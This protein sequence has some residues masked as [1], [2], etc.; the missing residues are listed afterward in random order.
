MSGFE[1]IFKS[2]TCEH[3]GNEIQKGDKKRK[4]GVAKDIG[5]EMDPHRHKPAG[6]G[7]VIAPRAGVH[8][9]GS[10]QR[11]AVQPKNPTV[12]N[13]SEQPDLSK[14]LFPLNSNPQLVQY[15]GPENDQSL[16]KSIEIA[17]QPGS[18]TESGLYA[19][20]RRNLA[21]EQESA[22]MGLSKADKDDASD[23]TGDDDDESASD[24]EGST[25][26]T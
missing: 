12:T 8:K 25:T 21:M 10:V 15:V 22:K 14:A 4:K 1:D 9:T 5:N 17:A 26:E 16:A 3:C 7:P 11:N 6:S 23:E 18:G 20:S 24:D 13:K 2:E 19:S